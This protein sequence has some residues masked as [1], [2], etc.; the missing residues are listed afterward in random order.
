MYIRF[1]RRK[2]ASKPGHVPSY[3]LH[4]VLVESYR[5]DGKPRQRIVSYLAALPENQFAIDNK[6]KEFFSKINHRIESLHLDPRTSAAIK[7]RLIRKFIKA[8]A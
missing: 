7:V 1:K 5:E 6:R 3:S 2:L 8:K 4:A